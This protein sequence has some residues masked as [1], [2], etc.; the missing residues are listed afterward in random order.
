MTDLDAALWLLWAKTD[1]EHKESGRYHPLLCHMIDV[2]AVTQALWDLSFTDGLRK[3]FASALGLTFDETRR[4]L[5]F[6][7]ALHDLGKASPGFQRQHDP[8]K[9]RLQDAG[10]VFPRIV[11][12]ESS[13]HGVITAYTLPAILEEA[14]A[15]PKRMARAVSC[16]VGGH[17]GSWPTPREVQ[18]LTQDTI[19]DGQWVSSRLQIVS[20]LRELF[21]PAMVV[22]QR[23]DR[24]MN[25]LFTLAS[26]LTSVADW[27]GSMED[28]FAFH[29]SEIGLREYHQEAYGRAE[30]AL[31]AL[32]WVGWRPPACTATFH[33]LF[34]FEPRSMQQNVVELAP[35]LTQPS[36]VII[37]APTGSGKT[38][39]ALYLADHW[40]QTLQQRGLYVAMPTMAT[41]NQM[42]ARVKTLLQ[43]RY[44][45][46]AIKPLL[47]HSQA[48]WQDDYQAH[49]LYANADEA[50]SASERVSDMSWFLARK[51]SLLAPLGVG[52]VDQSL[53]SV[54]QTRHFFVRL[55]GLAHKTIVFDE[56]HAYDTYMTTL[57][58]RLLGWLRAV[59]ASVILLS[60]TL[61][62]EVKRRLLE[63]YRGAPAPDLALTDYPAITWASGERVGM[64]SLPQGES[65]TVGIE[66]Q[67]RDP[68]AIAVRLNAE[69]VEG[70]YAAVICNTV[71]RAQEVYEA[72]AA[73]AP[74]D[75]RIILFHAQFPIA[76]R[77]VIESRVLR[78]CGKEDRTG[79]RPLG[80][81]IVVATQ[82]I[83]QSLDLDFDLIISDM[84]PL[85][86]L[87]QRAGRLHRHERPVRPQP[88]V[89]P[90]LLICRPEEQDGAISWGNDG[91]VYEPYILW[92]S[93]LALEGRHALH[94]PA[95][96]RSL[97]ESV[98]GA[99][100][101]DLDTRAPQVAAAR[102][103]RDKDECD[104]RDAAEQRLIPASDSDALLSAS[105]AGLEEETPDIHQAFQALTRLGPPSLSGV[106]LY[107][108]PNGL[109][110]EPDGTGPAIDLDAKP[111][112][113][114]TRAI[115]RHALS[116]T[117]PG[118]RHALLND[119]ASAP[120]GWHE[121]ALLRDHR[122]IILIDGTG[123]TGK[124]RVRLDREYGLRI[125]REGE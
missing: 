105:N 101:P 51:R 97:I 56:V 116:L 82:V 34:S 16:V 55:F 41:S 9:A 94:L 25:A 27:I 70:G 20:V 14:G 119:P 99:E 106:C 98:Y 93:Y 17:H 58:E 50:A 57:F 72:I 65:R 21:Q 19:G 42:Y 81:A 80:K 109:Y 84:A 1:R 2:A 33:D 112:R 39:A 48:R 71:R 26:G 90:R 102:A 125:T 30:H 44:P 122:I 18:K 49:R 117:H 46:L 95:E 15:M 35:N 110:L 120:N 5:A 108:T 64:E 24:Q 13:R 96:T 89:A 100:P 104:A 52:T 3:Q 79:E 67:D 92:R 60:A 29:E 4:T 123:E 62:A 113:R 61:P 107:Q 54:L 86:L 8:S 32:H 118:V 47:L 115:A 88:L 121:H 10:W 87:I 73:A 66:W 43:R 31:R 38:E 22:F 68:A 124:Y 11:G 12:R 53:L 28:F 114:L 6:W 23:T 63:A 111:M 45:G 91:Y 37:E 83:E 78:R 77:Q 59:D 75:T 103:K 85:D 7:A 40:A 36:L 69:L 76:W 74:D